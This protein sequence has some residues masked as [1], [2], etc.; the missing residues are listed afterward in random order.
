MKAILF[1]LGC[2]LG[3]SSLQA[4]RGFEVGGWIGSAFYFGDLN[5][6]FNLT[7]PGLAGGIQGRFNFNNRISLKL[8][9]NFARVRGTDEVASASFEKKRNLSFYSNVYD[10]SP[11]LEFNFFPYIHGSREDYFTP[12]MSVGFSVFKFDPKAKLDGELYKLRD[13]T[14]EGSENEYFNVS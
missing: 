14:T 1:V 8:S 10:V 3:M 2:L 9:G 12:Y 13:Y 11:V 7:K 4:Q 5:P 6:N